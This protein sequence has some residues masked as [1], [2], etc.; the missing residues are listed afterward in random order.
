MTTYAGGT[1]VRSGYY[2]DTSSFR[3]RFANVDRDGQALPGGAEA[4]WRKVP[5]LAVV[6][7]AP[8]LGG[9]FVVALPFLGFGVTA[10]A[11]ARRLGVGA[12]RGAEELAAT[13]APPF[14]PGEAHLTG[15]PADEGHDAAADA[16][17]PA[18]AKVEA[19]EK[20]IAERR[21]QK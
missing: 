14:V 15:K 20:E 6:A 1:Q 16:A 9:L 3:F 10:Y 19:L 17:A 21:G 13:M 7:A 18:D 11:V 5:V 2:L 12:R 8:V 4:R